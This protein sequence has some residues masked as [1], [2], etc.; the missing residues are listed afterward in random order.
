[1]ILLPWSLFGCA[2][3]YALEATPVDVNPGDVVECGFTE[4]EG[5]DFSSY[6]C[7]PVFTTTD[8]PTTDDQC[9]LFRVPLTI[10]GCCSS[11][12]I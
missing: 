7:N 10:M 4:V 3:D 6:D 2:Q 12:Y 5:T 1:V 9:P 8:E 11:K